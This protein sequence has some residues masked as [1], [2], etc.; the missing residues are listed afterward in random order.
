MQCSRQLQGYLGLFVSLLNYLGRVKRASLLLAIM[1]VSGPML[2]QK[3]QPRPS[4]IAPP[5]MR[6]A[7]RSAEQGDLAK[8][9]TLTQELLRSN[10]RYEPAVRLEGLILE[11]SGRT[12]EAAEAYQQALTLAPGD[13][14]VAMKLG[15]IRL[16]S[17]DTDVAVHLLKQRTT[18]SPQDGDAF[19]YLAQAYHLKGDNDA[20]VQ[21]IQ[22]SVK[23]EPNNVSV[24]QKYGELLC[25]TGENEKGIEWLKKSQQA[26]SSLERLNFDLA[27]AYYNSQDLENASQYALKAVAEHSEDLQALAL[28]G[29]ID[30]KLSQWENGKV[31]FEKLLAIKSDDAASLLGLGHCE[32]S[33]KNYSAAVTPLEKLLHN[34]PTMILAHFYLSRAYSGLGRTAEAEHEAAVH[35]KLLEDAAT[36]SD[37]AQSAAEGQ[38]REQAGKLLAAG[39]ESDAVELFRTQAGGEFATPGSPYLLTGTLYL[40]LDRPEDAV[41][42]LRKALST[43]PAIHQAH[44]YLAIIFLQQNKLSEAESELKAELSSSP[45]D[46]FATAELGAVRFRQGRWEEAADLLSKS[47]TV[48]PISLYMLADADFRLGRIKD[49]DVAAELAAG[50]SKGDGKLRQ[51]VLDLLSRNQQ[52]ELVQKLSSR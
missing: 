43:E 17:G 8:A 34:D 33:L 28:L 41:R 32:L 6:E 5:A 15:V 1:A 20:A 2:S 21:A 39:K 14:E 12:A 27:V 50:Y 23:D 48:A 47:K 51:A 24:W 45:Q 18:S 29:A 16:V 22:K 46:P 4:T 26:D 49:A 25:S 37:G 35:R 3:P 10:P 52:T 42:L 31:V 38:T 40:S 11:Q 30:V 36:P 7:I 44:T 13:S 19:Y 9:Y